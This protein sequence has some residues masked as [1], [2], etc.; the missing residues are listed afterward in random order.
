MADP[1]KQTADEQ[2]AALQTQLA[3]LQAI[4]EKLTAPAQVTPDSL[5]AKEHLR[6]V[7]LEGA[8]AAIAAYISVPYEK[9]SQLE[10]N[11][12]P[13]KGAKIF[14]CLLGPG[15]EGELPALYIPADLET[16]AKAR[17]LTACNVTSVVPDANH[18]E[19][20]RWTVQDVTNDPAAQAAV[21]ETWTYQPAA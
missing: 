20:T 17:Y 8:Q 6:A 5:W 3:N 9:R 7:A 10:T 16:D 4:V 18:P 14:R 15:R 12:L 21:K 11:K 1:K 2:I 19:F 13:F